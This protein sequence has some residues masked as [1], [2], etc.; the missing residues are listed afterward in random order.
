MK[1]VVIVLGVL[2]VLAVAALIAGAVLKGTGAHRA[3]DAAIATLPPGARITAIQ[4]SGD[5]IVL[6]VHTA[7]GDEV[8]IVDAESGKLVARIRPAR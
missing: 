3:A 2:I 1:M 8:D 4:T 5:R 6:G 7:D